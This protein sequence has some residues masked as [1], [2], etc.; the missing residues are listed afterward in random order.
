FVRVDPGCVQG[1][2]WVALPTGR[3]SGPH[4]PQ[5]SRSTSA[6]G[7]FPLAGM[8][9]QPDSPAAEAKREAHGV[10]PRACGSPLRPS[11]AHAQASGQAWCVHPG[12]GTLVGHP[13]KQDPHNGSFGL[14]LGP[15]ELLTPSGRACAR[16]GV[17]SCTGPSLTAHSWCRGAP[18]CPVSTPLG[19]P[20]WRV[21][22]DR[23]LSLQD[24]PQQPV[25]MVDYY[26]VLGVQRQASPEDIKKATTPGDSAGLH[27]LGTG[28]CADIRPRPVFRGGTGRSVTCYFPLGSGSE[29]P[30]VDIRMNLR[31]SC[32][33]PA[34]TVGLCPPLGCA[35]L[36]PQVSVSYLGLGG[37]LV[38][39]G[40]RGG[41]AGPAAAECGTRV[42]TSAGPGRGVSG[43]S[44]GAGLRVR[45]AHSSQVL[46]GS[47]ARGRPAAAS[48]ASLGTAQPETEGRDWAG[49]DR[50]SWLCPGGLGLSLSAHS[51][52]CRG[53]H[54]DPGQDP[55]ARPAVRLRSAVPQERPSASRNCTCVRLL[56][57]GRSFSGM[58]PVR[59]SAACCSLPAAGPACVAAVQ[60]RAGHPHSRSCPAAGPPVSFKKLGRWN[61]PGFARAASLQG[62]FCCES[63]AREL[64][65][66]WATCGCQ[67]VGTVEQ[68]EMSFDCRI[69]GYRKLALKWHPDKNPENKEEAERK[70]KQVAEAYE[71]LSDGESALHGAGSVVWLAEGTGRCAPT[72]GTR[73]AFHGYLDGGAKKRDIY[74]KYGKEG[75]SSGGGGG[76]HF[77]NPFE[78]GFTFRNPDDVFREFFGGR[79]PFSFDFFGVLGDFHFQ[80][81]GVYTRERRLLHGYYLYEVTVQPA[82]S[83]S[84]VDSQDPFE[85]FFGSRRGPRGS[86]NRGTGSFFSAFGGFPSFGGGFPAF[87]TGFTSFG[88]L[89]HGG[90]TSFSSTSFGG[91]GMGSFKSISTSTK[92]VNGRKITTKRIVE[93]GQER[94]EV[95]EDGQL[96]SL[97]VN[98][99][100]QLLR[101]DSK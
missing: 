65:Q 60:A 99:K 69:P 3:R 67:L 19:P 28:S 94:V 70:F 10:T 68:A 90:L 95:E 63:P 46:T 49:L 62:V 26:E 31:L 78:F 43:R 97:T 6:A 32:L 83:A 91:S 36:G 22:A 25:N 98:G 86:R 80:A 72:Q 33:C 66:I 59:A 48:L 29:P 41:P 24:S 13:E 50:A 40:W 45:E 7:G 34:A 20:P 89:G 74:D 71:V 35:S 85:D 100:E 57:A 5:E 17:S 2:R 21:A 92:I 27:G 96:K 73:R 53:L 39:S 76:S 14:L 12:A 84:S 16:L 81:L 56:R 88:S 101:L 30:E 38:C 75:L 11:P 61:S 42:S 87:D 44:P 23:A 79:D 9:G 37:S 82:G 64:P 47:P 4:P 54:S 58:L 52:W 77:D 51:G 18:P 15:S 93:N 8:A 55:G 1:W